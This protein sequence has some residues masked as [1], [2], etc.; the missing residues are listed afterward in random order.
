MKNYY[1]V[2]HV[3][4]IGTYWQMHAGGVLA[5]FGI[6]TYLN[7]I[8]NTISATSAND[9]EQ[10]LKEVLSLDKKRKTEVIR[11]VSV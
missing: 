8:T 1:L 10:R 6:F 7:S 2:K 5:R 4:S 11:L 3:D 9:C